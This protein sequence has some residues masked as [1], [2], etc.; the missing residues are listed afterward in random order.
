MQE[1]MLSGLNITKVINP[2]PMEKDMPGDRI[3]RA[4]KAANMSQADLAKLSGVSQP[5]IKKIES[6]ETR[7]SRYMPDIARALGKQL[8]DIDPTFLDRQ[9]GWLTIH[10]NETNVPLVGDRTLPV[11]GAVEGGDGALVISHEPVDYVRMPAPLAEVKDGYGFIIIGESMFP[12]LK[13]GHTALVHPHLPP[14]AGEPC[15]FYS[16][17]GNGTQRAIVKSFLRQTATH[18]FVE[19]RRPHKKFS[20]SKKEWQKCHRVVGTYYRR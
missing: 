4:R 7:K 2:G 15:V 13:P 20:L 16:D 18:W 3:K 1:Q 12:E 6:G 5:A 11:Y 19:Q 10:K 8:S 17:D 14:V 9:D